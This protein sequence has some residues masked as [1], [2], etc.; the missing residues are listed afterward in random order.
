MI[1]DAAVETATAVLEERG[2]GRDDE[3]VQDVRAAL[4]AAQ[5][6]PLYRRALTIFEKALPD[7]ATGRRNYATL[8]DELARAEEAAALRAKPGAAP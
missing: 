1:T 3:M 2:W 8:L 7:L 4:E 6:E 5:A